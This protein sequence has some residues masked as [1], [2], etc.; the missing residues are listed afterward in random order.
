MGERAHSA[1]KASPGARLSLPIRALTAALLTSCAALPVAGHAQQPAPASPSEPRAGPQTIVVTG[2]RLSRA[3]ES[4]A[5]PIQTATNR[6]FVLTGVANVEQTLNQ[7]PQL[8]GSFTTTSNNPGTGA[9]TLNLRGLG[10]VRTLVLVNGRRWIASDA[11]EVPE[12]DVNT[13]PAALIRRV[14][15]VTGGA[16][17]T[18]G[19]DA[20]TGVINF[21]TDR[22]VSGLRLD[23]RQAVSEHGD[24]RTS[25]AD[26]T[27]GTA[28]SD[29]RGRISGSI[30]WLDQTPVLQ[31]ARPL[32]RVSLG[33]GCVVPGTRAET[34]AS[35]P[36]S[37][38][39]NPANVI[40]FIAGGS[41]IIP[42]TRIVGRNLIPV[43]GTDRL[44]PAPAGIRFLPD[45]RA[46]PYNP[47]TDAYN[48]APDN[49]LQV[50]LQ[51]RSGN[52]FASF[53]IGPAIEPY[54]ELAYIETESPQQLAPVPGLLG[55]GT[56]TVPVARINLD[57]PFLAP[58]AIRIL[59]LSYGVDAQG[60]LGFIGNPGAG[61]RLNPAFGGDADRIVSLPGVLQSR[62]D[63][64]PRRRFNTREAVRALLGARGM[65]TSGWD[66]DFFASHSRVDHRVAFQNS[67]SARRLQQAL[68][69]VRDP[70]TGQP[71]CIDRSNGC[72]AANIFGAGNL[73]PAAADFI[74]TDPVELTIVD[75]QV[76]ELLVRGRFDL[77]SA[78][79][80]GVALG[81]SWRR[82]AYEYEPDPQ[83]LTGDDLGFQ[84]GQPAA[85]ETSVFELFAE[86]RLPLLAERPLF[87]EL[88]AELGLRWSSY[89][90]VGGVWTWKALL[91]WT[92]IRGVR[93]RGGYQRAVRAPNVR[94]LYE[95]PT[96]TFGGVM[97]PCA[98]PGL[99][100]A[101]T[102]R[103][104]CI[105]NGV[106]AQLAATLPESFPVQ[107]FGGDRNLRAETAD[108]FTAGISFAPAVV[109]GLSISVD[110]Y[111]IRIEDVISVVGGGAVGT[112]FG[113][114]LG[115]GDPADPLCRAYRRGSDGTVASM[116]LP[117]A[118][119]PEARARGI[120][121]QL[122][123]GTALG[124]SDHRVDLLLSGTHYLEN[125]YTSILAAPP[126]ECAG[127]FG[128]PCG[129]T[130]VGSATP[131]WKLFNSLTWRAGDVSLSLRHRWFSATRDARLQTAQR[132]GLPPPVLPEE[133][134]ELEGRHY[135]DLA[136]TFAVADGFNLIIGATNVTG[137]PPALTA[138]SQAQANTDPSLYDVLGRRFFFALSMK[139]H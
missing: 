84:P 112:V 115:G 21:I 130:I 80:A 7:L 6:D 74:R 22:D 29:G 81:A 48:F 59:D 64:G 34:G 89:D 12:V 92:P 39:C 44:T 98:A 76:A 37:G 40:G 108:T 60:R 19:S 109:P 46:V 9:A 69:A 97:D 139:F 38:A 57:N 101:P 14:D 135:L 111:D 120:D 24:A 75:E 129:N 4:S 13:I 107:F 132:F 26:L 51:R 100:D 54:V 73:S 94:E 118:N 58:E 53:E 67:G 104:A 5:S 20:V 83:L 55:G 43:P 50:P 125:S 110:Y 47:A 49:Y 113:C 17:A 93:L 85:G 134:R 128:A 33:E 105:R 119:V 35:T 103:A 18:Y 99:R 91:N 102:V 30:G 66:Y 3:N 121:W 41:L 88:D 10:S 133:G 96:A 131:R 86:A 28:F 116:N 11:G 56:G 65:L 136:A 31:G 16:S 36:V 72:V 126:L 87:H 90:T 117:A 42:G 1:I 63:L 95:A 32:S 124:G 114:I 122:S 138:G 77:F 2:S 61:F 8:V 25:S 137:A 15:I 27:A 106:P 68:L 52:L 79:P 45:G 23:A 123:L 127:Q 71:V 70:A 82:S 78:D 62:V